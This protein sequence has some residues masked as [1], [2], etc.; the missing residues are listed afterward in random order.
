L[1]FQNAY[2]NTLIQHFDNQFNKLDT[3]LEIYKMTG[4]LAL[5]YKKN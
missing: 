3:F 5:E 1:S 2:Q 4:K